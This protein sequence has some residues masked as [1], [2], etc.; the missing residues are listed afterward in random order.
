MRLTLAPTL[1]ELM[2]QLHQQG[3]SVGDVGL[4]G[5]YAVYGTKGM[6]TIHAIHG[7]RT[8]AWRLAAEQARVIEMGPVSRN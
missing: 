4:D 8:E 1:E 7:D 2:N 5:L 6:H 3:W